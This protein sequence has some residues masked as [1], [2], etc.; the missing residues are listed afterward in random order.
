MVDCVAEFEV[1]VVT[2]VM[3]GTGG[4]RADLKQV[5]TN[6]RAGDGADRD[7]PV[8]LGLQ[9]HLLVALVRRI[10]KGACQVVDVPAVRR[11]ADATDCRIAQICLLPGHRSSHDVTRHQIGRIG[12]VRHLCGVAGTVLVVQPRITSGGI[13]A[14][15]GVQAGELGSRCREGRTR[16]AASGA[17][18]V[19]LGHGGVVDRHV[20]RTRLRPFIVDRVGVALVGEVTVVRVC[21]RAGPR[22]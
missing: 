2:G 8:I 13:R 18:V 3:L 5:V 12:R 20:E 19:L 11:E 22:G 9:R 7:V 1:A 6:D 21:D 16:I 10:Q 14:W 15:E 4:V 17:G